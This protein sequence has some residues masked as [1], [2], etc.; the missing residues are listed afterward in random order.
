[1]SSPTLRSRPYWS[2][3]LV[4]GGSR[5]RVGLVMGYFLRFESC[6]FWFLSFLCVDSFDL[7]LSAPVSNLLMVLVFSGV[8]VCVCLLTFLP[9]TY[10][11][12]KNGRQR[13][14]CRLVVCVG[15]LLVQV[16]SQTCY[17]GDVSLFPSGAC[18]K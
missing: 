18:V 15:F 10:N 3:H 8:C 14:F 9:H 6:L 13:A 1:M 16:S 17:A 7:S 5:G 12:E 4:C 11:A 2:T